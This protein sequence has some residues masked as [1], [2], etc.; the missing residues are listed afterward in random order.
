MENDGYFHRV[1]KKSGY[2][3]GLRLSLC[4]FEDISNK[5]EKCRTDVNFLPQL[6]AD[7][8]ESSRNR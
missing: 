7:I 6:R 1:V 5:L 8:V 3:A 2:H 4:I